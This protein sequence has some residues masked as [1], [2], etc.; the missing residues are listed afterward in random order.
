MHSR[1]ALFIPKHTALTIV[2]V[3]ICLEGRT[4]C[5]CSR[6][7]LFMS[8]YI[9]SKTIV[10]AQVWL[11]VRTSCTLSRKALFMALIVFNV[12][13]VLMSE[14]T[15]NRACYED[16]SIVDLSGFGWNQIKSR[17]FS[18][19]IQ[20]NT[21]SKAQIKSKSKSAL[22]QKAQIKSKSKSTKVWKL[23]QATCKKF[24][25]NFVGYK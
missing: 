15:Q 16:Y 3:H 10:S 23:W 13:I 12:A 24:H 11:E 7:A 17:H 21:F 1:I 19:Q 14:W 2:S 25:L 9:E 18:N 20:I 4:Y 5:A 8:Q 22:F 6:I